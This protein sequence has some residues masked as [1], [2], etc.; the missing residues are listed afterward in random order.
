MQRNLE[1]LKSGEGRGSTKGALLRNNFLLMNFR[2]KVW[3]FK[4]VDYGRTK[5]IT[6]I[7]SPGELQWTRAAP[8]RK[9]ICEYARE[10]W[11]NSQVADRNLQ[12]AN[13]RDSSLQ[14]T[15]LAIRLHDSPPRSATTV[16]AFRPP[17]NIQLPS[18]E[19]LQSSLPSSLPE[20]LPERVRKR[21]RNVT[22]SLR[23]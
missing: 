18:L 22:E 3:K 12:S 10:L 8:F 2:R 4:K 7:C 5:I 14:F 1:S 21:E 19:W 20:S 23:A 9:A 11:L 6:F 13:L 16:S 17:L 15:Q